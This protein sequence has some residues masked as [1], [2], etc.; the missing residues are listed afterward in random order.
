MST[1]IR[2]SR[3][4]L[5]LLEQEKRRLGAKSIEETIRRLLAERRR[6]LVEKFF[7]ID[8]GRVSRFTED[9]RLDSCA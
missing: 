9:D 1:T 2:I 6:L 5:A 4:L 7:G 3:S 8:K